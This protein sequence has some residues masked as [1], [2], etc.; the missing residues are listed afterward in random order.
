MS[1]QGVVFAAAAAAAAVS[2]TVL[3]LT[4]RLQKSLQLPRHH[5]LSSPPILRSCISSASD[6]KKK[7]MKKKRVHFAEDVVVS[8]IRRNGDGEEVRRNYRHSNS[9]TKVRRSCSNGGIDESRGMPA[10]RV[11]LYNGI[12]KDRVAQR[13]AYS[14]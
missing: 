2:G 12:L 8:R 10:N 9:E 3:L 11:A 1:S 4:L 7:M 14:Y 6:E 13:L 5:H